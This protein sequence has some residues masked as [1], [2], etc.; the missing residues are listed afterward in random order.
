MSAS[1][2]S[3][4]PA[5]KAE[6]QEINPLLREDDVEKLFDLKL[7]LSYLLSSDKSMYRG[8]LS[9]HGFILFFFWRDRHE[10]AE[11]RPS[12]KRLPSSSPTTYC[13]QCEERPVGLNQFKRTLFCSADCKKEHRKKVRTENQVERLKHELLSSPLSETSLS[14]QFLPPAGLVSPPTSS[15][16]VA[17]DNTN[18]T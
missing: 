16:A 14:S 2:S 18:A 10:G 4:N 17:V 7:P 8:L 15:L 9:D 13:I 6:I 1:L 5:T 12:K 11:S 3:F